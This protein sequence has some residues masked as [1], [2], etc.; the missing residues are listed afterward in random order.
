MTEADKKS[1][2][3]RTMILFFGVKNNLLKPAV[4]MLLDPDGE[5]DIDDDQMKEYIE[6]ENIYTIIDSIEEY[7]VKN[8]LY[9]DFS[10][11]IMDV[12]WGNY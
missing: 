8:G 2:N 6:N 7:I 4:R 11:W 10:K 12:L 5:A 1:Y 3:W 9:K